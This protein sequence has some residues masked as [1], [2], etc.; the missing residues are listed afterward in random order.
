MYV[1]KEI[2]DNL[3]KKQIKTTQDLSCNDL[4]GLN[5]EMPMVKQVIEKN[6][7][8]HG[9]ASLVLSDNNSFSE[10]TNS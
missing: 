2:K 5:W 1:K 10:Q 4:L 9:G 6:V 7:R 3:G 8:V